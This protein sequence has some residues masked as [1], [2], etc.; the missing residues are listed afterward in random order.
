[1]KPDIKKFKV[2]AKYEKGEQTLAKIREAVIV[3]IIERGY[4]QTN[5]CDIVKRAKLT[6][7]A[8]YNYWNSLDECIIDVLNHIE[9]QSLKTDQDNSPNLKKA[10]ILIENLQQIMTLT[11]KNNWKAGYFHLSLLQE[12]NITSK[13]LQKRMKLS[14]ERVL[15]YWKGLLEEDKKKKIIQEK[16]PSDAAAMT[17]M[18]LTASILHLSVSKFDEY[19]HLQEESAVLFLNSILTDAYRKKNPVKTIYKE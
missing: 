13:E 1:M 5:V 18:S 9:D 7:G 17:L 2:F 4:H 8:F 11:V 19:Q 15:E 6:R 12:K 14:F 3:E 16:I 10:S